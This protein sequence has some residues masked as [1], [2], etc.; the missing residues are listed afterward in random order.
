MAKSVHACLEIAEC[1]DFCLQAR[2]SMTD[3]RKGASLRIGPTGSGK[4][5]HMAFETVMLDPLVR[6][7]GGRQIVFDKDGGNE[8]LVRAMGG[9]VA[10]LRRGEACDPSE[11][12]MRTTA[13]LESGDP[14]YRWLNR[15]VFVGT[16]A[17]LASA[18]Q[19][20]LYEVL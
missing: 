6:A 13:R 20:S 8:I 14:R 18:V 19:I 7:R 1:K 4:T 9:A 12:Y 15:L 10:R 16:G 11:Y 3:R 17:R 5:L 2:R